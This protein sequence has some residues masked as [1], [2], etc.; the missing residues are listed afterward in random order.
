MPSLLKSFRAIS[1]V[2][3]SVLC[4][5]L[6]NSKASRTSSGKNTTRESINM[7]KIAMNIMKATTIK[8]KTKIKIDQNR[9]LTAAN[10]E[11]FQ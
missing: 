7:M 5:I 3:K 11:A 2:D 10:P 6:L 9:I 1:C 8:R 4:K